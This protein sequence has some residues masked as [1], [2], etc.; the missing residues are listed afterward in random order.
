MDD[1]K[2]KNIQLVMKNTTY[3]LETTQRKLEE[4]N[5]DPILVIKDYMG[6]LKQPTGNKM[7]SVNQEIYKQIRGK[8]NNSMRNYNNKNPINID[9]VIENFQ[10]SEKRVKN[11]GKE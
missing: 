8:M 6:L 11:E 4:H 7:K 1:S 5:G 2:D 10:E 3:D 9:H